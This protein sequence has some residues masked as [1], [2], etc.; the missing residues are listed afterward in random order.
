MIPI[1]IDCDPGIDDAVA[2]MLAASAPDRF[3]LL[4][5]ST[6]FGNVGAAQTADNARRVL[7]FCGQSTVPVAKGCERPLLRPVRDAAF[8]HGTSG[9]GSAL[10]PEPDGA[11]DRRHG[12]DLIL[13]EIVRST[14]PV[15]LVT[16]GPLTNVALAIVKEPAVMARLQRIVIMGGAV[17]ELGNMPST[18]GFNLYAD[19][20]AAEI[21]FRSGLPLVQ[22]TIDATHHVRA[23]RDHLAALRTVGNRH[24]ELAASLFDDFATDGAP[25]PDSPV[26]GCMHDPCCIAYLLD[27]TIARGREAYVQVETAS[28][29][30][31]GR[32]VIDW[33][34]R[35]GQPANAFVINAIDGDAF[36]ALLRRQLVKLPA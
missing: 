27:P 26:N 17:R 5:V 9:L 21:V 1:L 22:M 18:A 2:L 25:E 4:G 16:L 3:R 11:L 33:W 6:V 31:M 12:V 15:T 10:L 29:V 7:A 35:S 32:S 20:H 14:D 13:D 23:S 24:A 30:S 36:F 19:P 28:E 34:G 8:I